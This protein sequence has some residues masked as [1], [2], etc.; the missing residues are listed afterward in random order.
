MDLFKSGRANGT[1]EQGIE[2]ALRR[3]LVSPN[4]LFRIE[5]D[6]EDIAPNTNYRIGDYELASR[7]S[8]FLWSSIPDDELLDAAR[9]GL[10]RQPQVLERQVKRMLAD[11]RSDAMVSNFLDQWLY[12]RN[13][14]NVTPADELF[15]DFDATL[16]EAFQR[17]TELFF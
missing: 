10:L 7:L 5:T 4:F 15:P 12:V 1:F 3:L 9:R 6:P 11:P 13:V 14:P 8:F 2:L 16:R 17:E